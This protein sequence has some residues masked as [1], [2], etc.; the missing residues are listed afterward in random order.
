MAYAVVTAGVQ[1]SLFCFY[2]GWLERLESKSIDTTFAAIRDAGQPTTPG[3][4]VTVEQVEH[5][6]KEMNGVVSGIEDKLKSI[7]SPG[8]ASKR[9]KP[10]KELTD[11]DKQRIVEEMKSIDK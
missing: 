3:Q 9:G 6:L 10:K 11:D 8:V 1:I 2:V 7:E 4:L 5:L